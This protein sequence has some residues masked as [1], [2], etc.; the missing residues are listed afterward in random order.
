VLPVRK[1]AIAPDGSEVRVLLALKGLG[2]A[3][4]FRLRAH[5][6]SRAVVHKTVHEIWYVFNGRG[7]MWRSFEGREQVTK[8][9]PGTCI[10][11]PLGTRFSI[12]DDRQTPVGHTGPHHATVADH[13][14]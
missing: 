12:Q 8:L 1:D 13:G 10:A 7:E 4:H 14:R 3:A 11:L 9:V 5:Q 6:V 2:S